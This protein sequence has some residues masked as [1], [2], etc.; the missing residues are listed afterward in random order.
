[1]MTSPHVASATSQRSLQA[2]LIAIMLN[3]ASL[4]ANTVDRN[5]YQ[6]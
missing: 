2:L 6:R 5:G 4:K 3:T 1:M